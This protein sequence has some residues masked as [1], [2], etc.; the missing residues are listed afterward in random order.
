MRRSS[1]PVLK[2]RTYLAV[3]VLGVLVIF[4][5]WQ[6]LSLAAP[7]WDVLVVDQKGAPLSGVPVSETW[8]DYS[9]EDQN[10]TVK[11]ATDS[12]GAAHF[13]PVQ[14]HRTISDCMRHT[15]SDLSDGVHASFGRHVY[16]DVA[17]VSCVSDGSGYC[18]DW[19]GHS[20]HML[21]RVV[22]PDIGS[23]PNR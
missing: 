9:C 22:L 14:A 3:A 10:H 18:V 2:A 21:S 4:S 8:Q 5:I 12:T 1:F 7:A 19:T 13:P 16:V 17:G 20:A 6:H 15:L 23:A 11:L